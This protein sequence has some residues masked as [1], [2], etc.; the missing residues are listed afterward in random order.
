ML[1]IKVDTNNR[2]LFVTSDRYA[3]KDGKLLDGYYLVDNLPGEDMSEYL[4][5]DGEFVHDPPIIPEIPATLTL[6]E[7]VAELEKTVVV[8]EYEPG[9]WYYRGNRVKFEGEIY[10][11]IAPEGTVCVWSPTEFAQYWKKG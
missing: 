4:Y 3:Q 9:K 2:V 6:E 10:T 5:V 8:D 7:R 11:C 1:A